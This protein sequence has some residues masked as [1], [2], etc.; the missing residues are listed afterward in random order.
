MRVAVQAGVTGHASQ[1]RFLK[2]L[3]L[4]FIASVGVTIVWDRSMSSMGDRPMPGGWT[5]S[6]AWVRMPGQCWFSAAASFLGMWLVMMMAMMLPAWVP[7][8][9]RYRRVVSPADGRR[10]GRL[11]AL[12]GAGYFLV[13]AVL[14]LLI[15]AFGAVLA[16]LEIELPALSRAVPLAAGA[17]V[18]TAGALQFTRWKAHHLSCCRAAPERVS[19]WTADGAAFRNGLRLGAHCGHCSAGITAFLLVVGVMDL[20]AMALAT[21]IIAFERLAPNGERI[22]RAFGV[23]LVGVGL[24]LMARATHR[25]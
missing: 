13:W 20:P 7:M 5:L 6:M 1:R 17:V 2:V 14:G 18:F 19:P 11:T 21:V 15:F 9:L 8:L 10:I 25:I 22:A 16:T 12:A 4:L 3:A 23:A 24:F